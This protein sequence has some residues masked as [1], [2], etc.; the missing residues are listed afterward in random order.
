VIFSVMKN[1]QSRLKYQHL[2]WFHWFPKLSYY[3]VS[4]AVKNDRQGKSGLKGK[5]PSIYVNEFHFFQLTISSL[6]VPKLVVLSGFRVCVKWQV[7][8]DQK[9]KFSNHICKPGSV[10]KLTIGPFPAP[11]LTVLSALI[12]CMASD[13][14]VRIESMCL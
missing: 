5:V 13:T 14:R 4:K 6:A 12:V 8:Q 3:L 11:E 7:G 10:F 9:D 2:R 1:E